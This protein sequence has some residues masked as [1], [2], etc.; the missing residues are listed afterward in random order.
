MATICGRWTAR[1]CG[2]DGHSVAA[3][4]PL[5]VTADGRM[6]GFCGTDRL[7][8]SGARPLGA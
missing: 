7:A 8:D 2:S 5:V 4:L 6:S 1:A 3:G